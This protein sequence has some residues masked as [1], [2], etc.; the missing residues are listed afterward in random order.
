MLRKLLPICAA[1]PG[2]LLGACGGGGGAGQGPGDAPPPETYLFYAGSLVAVDPANAGQVTVEAGATAGVAGVL[3]GSYDPAAKRVG[4][5]HPRSIV[6]AHGGRLY[7]VNAVKGG[8]PLTPTQMSSESG[9]NTICDTRAFANFADHDNAFYFYRLPGNDAVCDSA[10][11]VLKAVRL[12]MSATDTPIGVG[13]FKVLAPVLDIGSGAPGGWLFLANS[14]TALWHSNLNVS[15]STLVDVGSGALS[16]A[17]FFAYAADGRLFL[18]VVQTGFDRLRLY[19]PSTRLL[20]S[21]YHFFATAG[22]ARIAVDDQTLYLQ[23]GAKLHKLPRDGSATS[24]P[25]HDAGAN[26]IVGLAT[27]EGRVVWV[28]RDPAKVHRLN[29]LPKTGTALVGVLEISAANQDMHIVGTVG[30]RIYY[31]LGLINGDDAA[32]T[33]LANGTGKVVQADA[34]WTA[35]VNGNRADLGETARLGRFAGAPSHVLRTGLGPP[36]RLTVYDAASHSMLSE[37]TLP[38]GTGFLGAGLASAGA[39]LGESGIGSGSD[40]FYLE[41]ARN[42]SLIQLTDTPGTHERVV[43]GC[44]L[45]GGS[46]GGVDPMLPVLGLLA[47]AALLLRSGSRWRRGMG[48]I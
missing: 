43:G 16:D 23:D 36:R 35:F 3:H 22:S 5:L 14:G 47:V 46:D 20:S 21:G 11:D 44:V 26:A 31:N 24:T 25:F 9:A 15:S 45:A 37:S 17:E 12:G 39:M 32:G 30:D 2:L 1:L 33:V 41:L 38:D 28:T 10:D 13:A 27:T 34:A 48:R 4:D 29:T 7:K 8:G 40:V 42:D 6:Y 18:R 19:N